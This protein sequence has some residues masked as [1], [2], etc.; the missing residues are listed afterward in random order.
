MKKINRRE[1]V[2]RTSAIAAATLAV[3]SFV[4]AA[5]KEEWG[6]LT[7]RFVVEGD[8]PEPKKLVVDKDVD[9]CGKFDIRDESLLVDS[10]GG[11]SNVY[12]YVR[13][14]KVDI[15]P[16]LEETF[17]KSVLLDNRD[18]IF[19][20]HCMAI[21][22]DK[23]ILDIVNSD[24][25]AQNV[26]FSPLGGKAANIVLPAPPDAAAKATWTFKRKQRLPVK[27]VC[28]YH[29]WEVAYILPLDHPYFAI[30]AVDGT[31]TIP[32]LPVGK[33]ELQLW[34]ERIGYL[35]TDDYAKGRVKMKIKPGTND[36]GTI[37]LPSSLFDAQ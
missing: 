10:K 37:K 13:S 11:L 32:K 14:R 22:L 18:C 4:S 17:S 9:C 36:L 28:N 31:F 27:I 34:Q 29:P 16:E 2:A 8:V 26:A 23:Q 35:A 21:W 30:S 5:G 24:P 20:P 25:V 1:F 3:P 12:V 15:C 7:G 6:D 19:Q 33:I